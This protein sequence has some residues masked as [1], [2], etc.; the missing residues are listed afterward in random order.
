MNDEQED[1]L[2]KLIETNQWRKRIPQQGVRTDI[3]SR[4]TQKAQLVRSDGAFTS[5]AAPSP[6]PV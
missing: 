5:G 3:P 2:R 4:E 6:Q 1:P